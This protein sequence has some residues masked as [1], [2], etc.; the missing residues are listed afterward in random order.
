MHRHLVAIEISVIR[1]TNERVQLD[2]FA[3][4]QHRLEGLDAE[5]M[6]GRRPIQQHRVLANHLLQNIPNLRL[7]GL[8]QLLSLLDG[9]GKTA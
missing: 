4:D 8:D 7:L 9:G 6:Q 3:L 2:C 5:A 1:G